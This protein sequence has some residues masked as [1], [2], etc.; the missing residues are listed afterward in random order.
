MNEGQLN[1]YNMS[2]KIK[3]KSALGILTKKNA[4]RLQCRR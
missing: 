3:Y 2:K 1:G 4:D